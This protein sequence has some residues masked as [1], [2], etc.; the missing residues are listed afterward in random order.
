LRALLHAPIDVFLF[1]AR[2][3]YVALIVIVRFIA[4]HFVTRV[5]RRQYNVYRLCPDEASVTHN[6]LILQHHHKKKQLKVPGD[7]IIG[8]NVGQSR[9]IS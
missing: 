3:L 6:E 8:K 7:A 9:H 5:V 2:R 1:T 4:G